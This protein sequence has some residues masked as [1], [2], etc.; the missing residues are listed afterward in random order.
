MQFDATKRGGITE[1]LRI[2]AYCQARGVWLAPH[3]DPPIHG[4]LLSASANGFGVESFTR[5]D[6]DPVWEGLFTHRPEIK[7]GML[8]L[9]EAPGF[10]V[11]INWDFVKAP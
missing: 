5:S 8:Y 10:G 9:T 2:A 11:G 1:W 4:H 3:R 7:N 6:R